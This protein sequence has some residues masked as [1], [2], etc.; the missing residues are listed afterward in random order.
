MAAAVVAA[1]AAAVVVAAVVAV[2]ASGAETLKCRRVSVDSGS[3]S[4]KKKLSSFKV[5]KKTNFK[6]KKRPKKGRPI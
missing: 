6:S 5:K 4:S 2:A 3:V 1:A